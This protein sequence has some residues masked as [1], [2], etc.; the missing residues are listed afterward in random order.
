MERGRVGVLTIG[1]SPR[2]DVTP[3]IKGILGSNIEIIERGGLDR[4]T[5]ET[6]SEITPGPTTTT[7]YISRLRNGKSVK[8]DKNKLLPLLQEELT[9]LEKETDV[10]IMLCT[11]DFPTLKNTKPVL[12]P[13]KVLRH[14]VQAIMTKGTLGLI[15]PLEEQKKSLVE[16]WHGIGMDIVVEAA[17]PY[18]ESDL[19]GA[20]ARLKE[21]GADL[22]VLDCMGYHESH[23]NEVKQVFDGPVILPRTLIARI[24]AEYVF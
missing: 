4:L 5:E 8:I 13:D 16:K 14:S 12:Y 11:G 1:Q 6:L 9:E 15:I 3:S 18:E 19:K 21:K 24:A 2:T 20:G 23:K 22:I 17:S 7:T 10:T